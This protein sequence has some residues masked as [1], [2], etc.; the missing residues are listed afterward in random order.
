VL[1]VGIAL[2]VAYP[3]TDGVTRSR[4]TTVIV[5]VMCAA[6]VL[7]TA[8]RYGPGRAFAALVA[9][10]GIGFAAEVVGTATG[11]PFGTYE[12]TGGLGPSLASVPLIV[13]LAW[14][15]GALP[16]LAA[17]ARLTA[18]RSRIATAAVTGLGLGAWDVFLDPQ[19]V[20]DGRWRWADPDP[21]LLGV[22]DVPLTNFAGWL[23]VAGIVGAVLCV[24]LRPAAPVPAA[25]EPAEAQFLWIYTASVLAHA[26]FL[27]LP[28]SAAWGALVMGAIAVPL[29]L[30]LMRAAR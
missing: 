7:A 4:L 15:M 28:G 17:A 24:L 25:V 10:A 8:A 12:Y 13:G 20:A 22:P 14:A 11:Y 1:A 23:L 5:V 19:M 26:V 2:Q 9:S 16:A 6:A 27:G 21:H 3:L 29:A 30:R 18:G